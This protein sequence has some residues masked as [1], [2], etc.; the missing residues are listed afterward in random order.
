MLLPRKSSR[1][2]S[3]PCFA[4]PQITLGRR[5]DGQ[6]AVH[7]LKKDIKQVCNG[8]W[9]LC[10]QT[11]SIDLIKNKI[12][13]LIKVEISV[14]QCQDEQHGSYSAC[15]TGRKRSYMI[16]NYKLEQYFSL[17]PNQPAVNNPRSSQRL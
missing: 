3:C 2:Q 12:I 7:N 4:Y 9:L 15:S 14:E 13:P 10:A 16:M 11:T 17:T 8:I 6:A 5:M 1:S